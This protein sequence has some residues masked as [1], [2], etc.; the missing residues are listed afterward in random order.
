MSIAVSDKTVFTELQR[1]AADRVWPVSSSLLTP[2]LDLN[3]NLSCIARIFS[4]G[5]RSNVIY[6]VVSLFHIVVLNKYAVRFPF[7]LVYSF[8]LVLMTVFFFF[9]NYK[10]FSCV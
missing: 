4:H 1:Q 8:I 9:Q 7:F 2:A 10:L 5:V 3:L 6:I